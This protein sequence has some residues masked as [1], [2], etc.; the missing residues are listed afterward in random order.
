MCC[1]ICYWVKYCKQTICYIFNSFIIIILNDFN[2]QWVWFNIWWLTLSPS[3]NIVVILLWRN[4]KNMTL[5]LDFFF[6]E[7]QFSI[8]LKSYKILMCKKICL[9]KKYCIQNKEIVMNSIK[10]NYI[11]FWKNQI[12]RQT[13]FYQRIINLL[14]NIF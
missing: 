12:L 5:T 10:W 13:C 6:I 9:V 7:E 1:K 3:F 8:D 11:L 14:I 4:S 2:R